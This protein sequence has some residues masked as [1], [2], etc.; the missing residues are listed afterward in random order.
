MKTLE[1]ATIGKGDERS[2]PI[3]PGTYPAHVS[4]VSI[5]EY[6]ESYVYNI[7]YLV[8]PEVE[9]VSINKMT[10]ENDELS[11]VLDAEGNP[12]KITASYLAGKTFRGGGVWLTPDPGD[13]KWKNRKY[14]QYFESLGIVFKVDKDENTVLGQV[15][16][17]DVLGMPCLI[18]IALEE[19]EDKSGMPRKA[20]KVFTIYPWA[21][22]SRIDPDEMSAD[23]PF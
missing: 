5:K 19:Y 10:F 13:D 20:W 15:E 21:N 3:I 7:T 6:N 18:K 11:N 9:K 14:K 23:V 1:S 4:D 17:S 22:G 8:A 16:E 12:V 2:L